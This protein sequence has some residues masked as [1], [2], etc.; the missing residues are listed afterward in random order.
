MSGG[1]GVLLSPG[2][3]P[4]QTLTLDTR[5]VAGAGGKGLEEGWEMRPRVPGGHGRAGPEG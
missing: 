1:M 2:R 4:L 3:A 5:T